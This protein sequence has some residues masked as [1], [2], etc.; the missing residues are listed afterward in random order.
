MTAHRTHRA[1]GIV[2]A[3]TEQAGRDRSVE[4]GD[5]DHHR[6]FERQESEPPLGPGFE[7]LELDRVRGNIGQVEPGQRFHRRLRVIVGRPADQR[8]ARQVD[9]RID[10]RL[11]VLHEEFFDRRACV[12]PGSEGRNDLQPDSLHRSDHAIV[13][14]GV[15]TQQV[16][17]Q[18]QQADPPMRALQTRQQARAFRNQLVG[19][20]MIYADLGI[21]L[22]R[23]GMGRPAPCL[24]LASGVPVNQRARHGDHVV[25][26]P[27]EPV[28]QRQE[29]GAHILRGAGDEFEDLGQPAQHLHLASARAGARLA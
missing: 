16:G 29:I 12:E 13:V 19:A 11:P 26:R 15:A 27:G 21:F 14:R 4:F 25:V 2:A 28:L 17:A 6:G 22:R 7:R 23:V 1:F 20:R 24:A 3:P 9:D 10:R 5:C 18:H 8:E